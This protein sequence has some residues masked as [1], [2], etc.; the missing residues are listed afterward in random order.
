MTTTNPAAP[1]WRYTPTI[2]DGPVVRYAFNTM[3][4]V[5]ASRNGVSFDGPAPIM[6]IE[7][8]AQLIR[9][10]EEAG[11]AHKAIGPGGDHSAAK[12]WVEKANEEVEL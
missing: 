4:E 12:A 9:I 10:L 1:E 2:M 7:K 3:F 5:N 6:K 11:E 8:L